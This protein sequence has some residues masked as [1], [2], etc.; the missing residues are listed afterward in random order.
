VVDTAMRYQ[1]WSVVK[2]L[3]GKEELKTAVSQYNR[4]K[5]RVE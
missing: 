2:L 4:A 5:A 1:Q 3:I